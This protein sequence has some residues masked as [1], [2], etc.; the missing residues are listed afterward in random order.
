MRGVYE[1]YV[2]IA[3]VIAVWL[4]MVCGIIAAVYW[5]GSSLISLLQTFI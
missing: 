2:C 5:A 3:I 4:L 1:F